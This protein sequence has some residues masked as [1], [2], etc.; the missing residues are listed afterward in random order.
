MFA[1]DNEMKRREEPTTHISSQNACKLCSPLGASI[2]FKGIKGCLPLI[3]G[4]QG[5]A[6]YIRRYAISHFREPMDIASSNFSEESTIYGGAKNFCTGIDNIRSQYGPEVIAISSTCLSE[7][8]GEDVAGLIAQYKASHKGSELPEFIYA[9]TPSYQGTHM[10]G[11][12]HAVYG[13]A[14]WLAEAGPAT[15]SVNLMPGFVSTEDLR[16]LHQILDAFG[17]KRC[18]LP[19]YS[20]TLDNPMWDKYMTIPSGGTS[21]DDIKASGR[22]RASIEFGHVFC[23]GT[24]A[25][26]VK[27]KKPQPTAGSFLQEKFNVPNHQIG[28]PIGID[29]TDK[30]F[31]LLEEISGNPCPQQYAAER[32]R[33]IDSYVDAHKHLFGVKA[34]VYGEEDFAL[35]ISLFLLEIGMVP[36]IV[37]SGGE[38]GKMHSIL[39]QA[40]PSMIDQIHVQQGADF[41]DIAKLAETMQ[42]EIFIGNS[43]AYY[44]T[45]RLKLPLVRVGFPIHDR[46]GGQRV[47]HLAYRGTQELFD[48]IVNAIIERKQEASPVGYKYL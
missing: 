9:S 21:V 43:K 15:D 22:A 19:D 40:Y 6:T 27:S 20:E 48:R 34:A 7:T 25:G 41:E 3:H 32:G 45:R 44:I 24:V 28:M 4:S 14:S 5:C 10:D 11:F 30:F 42:P 37:A 46:F 38:S 17:I 31:S 33:L 35:A 29:A 18:M 23:S 16:N 1:L 47:A 26:R 39:Q 2:A 12:H 8:I 36:C 13:M